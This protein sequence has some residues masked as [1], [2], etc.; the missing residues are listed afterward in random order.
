MAKPT[1]KDFLNVKKTIQRMLKA[2]PEKSKGYNNRILE[3]MLITAYAETKLGTHKNTYSTGGLM[4]VK[5]GTIKDLQRRMKD[6]AH[7]HLYKMANQLQ[8]AGID[9]KNA[10]EKEIEGDDLLNTAMARLKYSDLPNAMPQ[11]NLQAGSPE[12]NLELDKGAAQWSDGYNSKLDKNGTK[13]Y[14]HENRK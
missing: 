10:T 4:Q 11:I 3:Q 13:K 12:A 8:R 2:L 6:P 1:K 9:V 5:P 7:K 14:W